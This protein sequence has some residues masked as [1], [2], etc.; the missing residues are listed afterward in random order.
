MPRDYSIEVCDRLEARFGDLGLHRPMR[1]GHYDAGARCVYRMQGFGGAEPAQV[2]LE[3][4]KFVGG[5]FAGQVYRVKVLRIEGEP[6]ETVEV[7]GIYAM[8]ILIPPSRGSLFFR[9]LLY[10]AGFQGP[11]QLQVN[12]KAARAGALWQKFIRRAAGARFGDEGSVNDIL[13]TFVDEKLGSCGEISQWVEGRTWRLEVDDRLDLLR[14]WKKGRP[15]DEMLL[16]SDEYRAKKKFMSDFVDLLHEMGAHEFARQYEW[17]T[18]KSQPNCLKRIDSGD[19]PAAGLVAVDFRAGLTL[20]PFLPMSPGDFGLILKGLGR[21]SLVQFDRGSIS[22]LESYIE[23]NGEHFAGMEPLLAELKEDEEVYRNSVPDVTHNHVRLL[24]SRKLWST[25]LDSAVTGWKIRG[26]V[27]EKCEKWLRH[28]KASTMLFWFLG[29]IP[30]L[31]RVLRKMWGRPD[32]RRH[33]VK[34]LT[35]VGYFM[36]ALKGRSLEKIIVWHRKGRVSAEKAGKLA[37]STLRYMAYVPFS[38]LPAGLARFLTDGKYFKEKL[39]HIFV[40]PILL[41]FSRRRREEWMREMV[42]EGRRKDLLSEED[43]ATILAQLDE[44]YI[45]RYL[46]SLVVH[47]LTLPVTQVVSIIVAYI[48]ARTHPEMDPTQRNLAVTGILIMFQVVPISPGSFCRGLYTTLLAIYDRSFKDY[49]IAL[50]LSYFKYVGYLAF[51]I[52]MAYSYPA[53]ARFM[54]AHWA[55]GAVRAVPVFGERGALLEHW[56]FC[57][58]YNWPL[59]LRRRISKWA[60]VRAQM[61]PRYWH[62]PVVAAAGAAVLGLIDYYYLQRVGELPGPKPNDIWPAML[63]VPIVCGWAITRGARGASLGRRIVMAAVGGVVMGLFYAAASTVVGYSTG[64]EAK[65][66]VKAAV[67]RIFVFSILSTISAFV[68]ELR[69]PEPRLAEK[70]QPVL[71]PDAA[72]TVE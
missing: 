28:R 36:R 66:L 35:N 54:A 42:M 15:V 69:L 48:F 21:G 5:G 63:L 62:V 39:F 55:T 41:F 47:L 8:K 49:N 51:P 65:F 57:L 56:V 29:L 13:A 38:I 23:K 44:P 40:R 52:Q 16:G 26:Y 37:N 71:S 3:I 64:I 9:N 50:F 27:D 19:D 18:C 4:E 24:Y 58:F 53:M 43:A 72:Q 70:E 34:T 10:Y 33:Y 61:E 12:P 32:W 31:G 1:I 25:M 20:L 2:E 68:M 22:R 14:R 17:S 6:V 67:W 60:Q 7:G 45:Q 30:I 11:F 46:I 59:T